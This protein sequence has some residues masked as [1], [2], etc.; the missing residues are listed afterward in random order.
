MAALFLPKRSCYNRHHT[1][2][3]TQKTKD[4]HYECLTNRIIFY[5]THSAKNKENLSTVYGA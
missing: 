3:F 5:I 2:N 1:L 4:I